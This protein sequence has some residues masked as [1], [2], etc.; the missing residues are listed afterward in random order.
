MKL[1]KSKLK[2]LIKEVLEEGDVI[3]GPRQG[4]SVEDRPRGEGEE[5]REFDPTQEARKLFDKDLDEMRTAM[6]RTSLSVIDQY[7][8]NPGKYGTF[9]RETAREEIIKVLEATLN[10]FIEDQPGGY[11]VEPSLETILDED[12]AEDRGALWDDD[13]EEEEW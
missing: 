10:N 12:F 9:T 5:E 6:Q 2:Q 4:A 11:T 3:K 8:D 1:T 7:R 13:D